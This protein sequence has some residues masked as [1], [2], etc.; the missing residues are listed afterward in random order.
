MLNIHPRQVINVVKDYT[1]DEL[2]KEIKQN[3]AFFAVIA[4]EVTEYYAN[5]EILS[6]CLRYV[7]ASGDSPCIR[8]NFY[9]FVGLERTT[10]M[11]V[12][13]AIH[14]ALKGLDTSLLRGQAYEGAAVMSGGRNGVQSITR[15]TAP[16]A[17]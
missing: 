9:D 10:A 2:T 11:E 17:L 3:K 5:R 12:S 6:M 16:K 13:S 4:D 7:D 15:N 1:Q 14:D 8:E